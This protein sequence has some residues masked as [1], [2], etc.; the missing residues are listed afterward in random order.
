MTAVGPEAAPS[1]HDGIESAYAWLRLTAA[2]ALGTIGGV[3]IWSLVVVLP[4][5]QAEFGVA[6]ADASLPYTATMIAFTFGGIL[7]GRLSD[8]FGVV[9]PVV[10]GGVSLCLG[11]VGAAQATSLWQFIAAQ[12]LLV[13]ALGSS[14]MFAPLIADVSLWFAKRRG[15]AVGICASGNYL[16]GTLWPPII[17]RMVEA[18]GWRTT[19]VAMGIFCVVTTVPLALLALRR[20]PPPQPA[21][22]Q[23]S[24]GTDLASTISPNALQALLVVAGL[25]CCFAMAMP[26]VHIV[27]YC[28]DL[29]YGPARGADM[30]ALMLGTGVVSRLASGWIS[31]RIGGVKTMLLG[32][33][34][35]L[36]SLILYLPFDGLASLYLVSAL[37]GL[38]QG[39]IVP[40][41]AIIVRERLPAHEAGTRIGLVLM[42]TIAGMALGGWMTGAIFDWSGSYR[43]AFLVGIFWNLVNLAI[44]LWLLFNSPRPTS[45]LSPRG[46]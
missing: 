5:V 7:M 31:D 16:A 37:F 1:R 22:S 29:G 43:I 41:Y 25:T 33:S 11:Y 13:G 46:A 24:S 45:R 32:S 26:Q 39:G 2:L 44:A 4:A 10:L 36:L 35:Q 6:R 38:V 9:V 15:T 19:F 30:L 8:R 40:S 23:A 42:S 12:A 20:R 18:Y 28:S 21:P 34:L 27:A 14:G 3:G 17:T